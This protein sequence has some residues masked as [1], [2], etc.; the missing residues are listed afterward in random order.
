MGLK[1]VDDIKRKEL[2]ESVIIEKIPFS[3]NEIDAMAK[4]FWNKI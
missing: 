3:R 2:L 1:H 4:H